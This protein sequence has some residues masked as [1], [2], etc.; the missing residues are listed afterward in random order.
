MRL[1]LL[2]SLFHHNADFV[3]FFGIQSSQQLL[4]SEVYFGGEGSPDFVGWFWLDG[5]GI[6]PVR[7]EAAYETVEVAVV[8]DIVHVFVDILDYLYVLGAKVVVHFWVDN[9]VDVAQIFGHY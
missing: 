3:L 8:K 4:R 7:G 1:R 9:L 6:N 2:S 5:I